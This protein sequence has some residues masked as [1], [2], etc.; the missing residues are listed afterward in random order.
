M[1][2]RF[3]FFL[4]EVYVSQLCP[5]ERPENDDSPLA[6]CTWAPRLDTTERGLLGGMA[7]SR[8]GR[9]V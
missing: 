7:D 8:T 5:L 1:N 9:D 2:L 3:F 4:S 6:T